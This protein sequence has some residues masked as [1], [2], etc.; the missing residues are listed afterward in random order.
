[1]SRDPNTYLLNIRLR[2]RNRKCKFDKKQKF[3]YIG[4]GTTVIINKI[5][6]NFVG[7]IT[8]KSFVYKTQDTRIYCRL[9]FYIVQIP[10]DRHVEYYSKIVYICI[11]CFQSERQPDSIHGLVRLSVCLIVHLHSCPVTVYLGDALTNAPNGAIFNT[12]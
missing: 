2:N 1:M 3:L 12:T 8:S 11:F 7:K 10:I 9:S 6:T 5:Q 4:L